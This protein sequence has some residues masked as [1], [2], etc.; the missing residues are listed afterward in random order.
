MA[1]FV[2]FLVSRQ[3]TLQLILFRFHFE[4][5]LLSHFLPSSAKTQ[6]QKKHTK[7]WHMII[8][9]YKVDVRHRH[10]PIQWVVAAGHRQLIARR[11]RRL[12]RH[13]GAWRVGGG[14][15][16]GEMVRGALGGGVRRCRADGSKCWGGREG[17]G[18]WSWSEKCGLR[19][20]ARDRRRKSGGLSRAGRGERFG[21]WTDGWSKCGGWLASWLSSGGGRQKGRRKGGGGTCRGWTKRGRGGWSNDT[22][23]MIRWQMAGR[24]HFCQLCELR[25]LWDFTVWIKTKNA[26]KIL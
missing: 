21:G 22:A 3:L 9:T 26:V 24:G 11:T 15:G 13:L 25:A 12:L 23:L 1:Y 18:V 17:G 14:R 4:T 5:G 2:C 6:Q 10:L 20:W 19:K 16:R 8:E 7:C